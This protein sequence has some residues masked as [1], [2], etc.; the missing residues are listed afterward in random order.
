MA[1]VSARAA[2][3]TRESMKQLPDIGRRRRPT[4]EPLHG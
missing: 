1:E 4:M 2:R 3:T